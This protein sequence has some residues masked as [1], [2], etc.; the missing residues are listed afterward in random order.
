[1]KHYLLTWGHRYIDVPAEIYVEIADNL[2]EQ[3]LVHIFSDGA[4]ECAD[5]SADGP[6]TALSDVPNPPTGP[7]WTDSDGG[8]LAR[9]LGET[10]SVAEISADAFEQIWQ[11]TVSLRRGGHDR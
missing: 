11:R 5:A 7:E 1:M 10:R 2:M 3:R 4:I 9:E 8:E 6:R